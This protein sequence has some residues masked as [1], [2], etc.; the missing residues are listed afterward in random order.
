MTRNCWRAEDKQ[1]SVRETIHT[2]V[3]LSWMK[4]SLSGELAE[5]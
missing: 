2:L 1:E 3:M 4:A 5:L